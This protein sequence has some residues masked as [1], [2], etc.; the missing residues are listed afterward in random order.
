MIEIGNNKSIDQ[1]GIL[2]YK[3]VKFEDSDEYY[4]EFTLNDGS[5]VVSDGFVTFKRAKDFT[6]N[7]LL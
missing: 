2:S 3:I 6:E 5:I 4:V 1:G 7:I